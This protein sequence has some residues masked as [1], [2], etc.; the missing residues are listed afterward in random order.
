MKGFIFPSWA[1]GGPEGA[2]RGETFW[3]LLKNVKPFW[4]SSH[5]RVFQNSQMHK[6]G[7]IISFPQ[8]SSEIWYT[9][10]VRV[11]QNSQM[12]KIGPKISFPQKSSEI[13]YTSHVRVLQYI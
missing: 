2:D 4:Y 1:E 7:P 6:I 8:K 10:H 9:S 12:H 13:W 5:V 3:G 11:F